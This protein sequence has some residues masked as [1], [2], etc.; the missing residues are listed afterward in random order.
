MVSNML[1][2]SN[3]FKIEKNPVI[4][5]WNICKRDDSFRGT[6]FCFFSLGTKTS[7][8]NQSTFLFACSLGIK[9]VFTSTSE[10]L[11]STPHFSSGHLA[12]ASLCLSLYARRSQA[13]NWRKNAMLNPKRWWRLVGRWCFFNKKTQWFFVGSKWIFWGFFWGFVLSLR[14]C[15]ISKAFLSRKH[16]AF[17]IHQFGSCLWTKFEVLRF[18]MSPTPQASHPRCL[19]EPQDGPEVHALNRLLAKVVETEAG[20]LLIHGRLAAIS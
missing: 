20:F 17:L 16:L 18:T 6:F 2:N 11:S 1:K 10:K 8:R 5:S 7:N 3:C 13:I 19:Q 12:G 15:C 9:F 14:S 4:F